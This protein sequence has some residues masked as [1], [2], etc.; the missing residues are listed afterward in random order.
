MEWLSIKM[1]SN[2]K[3]VINNINEEITSFTKRYQLEQKQITGEITD[4]IINYYDHASS[5]RKQTNQR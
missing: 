2:L 3:K 1:Y 4:I 5:R